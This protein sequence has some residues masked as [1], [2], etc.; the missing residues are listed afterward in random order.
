MGSI[1]ILV[2]ILIFFKVGIVFDTLEGVFPSIL[3]P[4]AG[5]IYPKRSY[6]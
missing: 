5:R 4:E 6:Q 1:L 3:L 2:R